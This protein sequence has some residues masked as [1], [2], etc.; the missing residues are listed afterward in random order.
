MAMTE[1]ETI[2]VSGHRL[3]VGIRRGAHPPLLLFNGIGANLELLELVTDALEGIET[4]VFDVPGVGGSGA[5]LRPYRLRELARLADSMLTE[6]GY[7]GPVDVL[8]VAWGGALTQ[9]F[10]RSHPRRCRWLVLAATTP[11]SLMV[12]GSLNALAK[13]LGSRRYNDAE[14][15]SRIAPDL[16]GGELR[17]NPRLI[18]SHRKHLRRPRMLGY[19]HQQMAFVGWS[20]LWW[21]PRLR[22]PTLVLAGRDDPLV[23]LINARILAW[24]IPGARLEVFDDGHLFLMTGARRVTPMIR[25]FLAAPSPALYP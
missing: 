4:I 20:S 2:D 5:R 22:Q 12:P 17:R 11:G 21:L 16:Y 13:M 15:L 23:P 6:L 10:A 24:L 1:I 14:Y 19:L 25:E 7:R 18:E 8:G 9:Q 3:R